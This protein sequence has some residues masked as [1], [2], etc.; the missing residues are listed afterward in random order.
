MDHTGASLQA[1]VASRASPKVILPTQIPGSA[2]PESN[3]STTDTPGVLIAR[4]SSPVSIPPQ[5]QFKKTMSSLAGENKPQTE[6]AQK[7]N[8]MSSLPQSKEKQTNSSNNKPA[9][10]KKNNSPKSSSNKESSKA[11][12]TKNDGSTSTKKESSGSAKK[13]GASGGGRKDNSS[14]KDNNPSNSKKDNPSGSVKRENSATNNSKSNEKKDN[15]P[16]GKSSIKKENGST[17]GT[18]TA[19]KK[20]IDTKKKP[21]VKKETAPAAKP[22]KTP[23]KLVAA[24]SIKSPS[25]LEV[26]ERGKTQEEPEEPALIVDVPLY[27]TDTNEYLDENGQVVFN[28]YK[29]VQDKFSSDNGGGNPTDLKAAKRNLFGQISGT[30]MDGAAEEDDDDI[31][32]VEEEGEEEEEEEGEEPKQNVS[33]KKKSHPNKGKSLIGKYDTEDPFIDDTEL[34][35]E[36]QR[37]ATKDGF[38][39]YFGPLIEKGH[40]A[41]LERADGTMKRGGVKNK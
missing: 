38:F 33:P 1:P 34:L 21:P 11:G 2:P 30:Q 41:S 17:T 31:E 16:T 10:P 39:V 3:D 15:K 20:P 26:L 27:S 5:A 9:E 32:E 6:L 18:S 4:M 37:A 28:F 23:K 29:V 22:A 40:Y 14:G 8:S 13:D 7:S 12:G 25:L 35:W 36:E 19:N 24:P